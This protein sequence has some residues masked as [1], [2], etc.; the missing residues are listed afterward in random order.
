MAK[1]ST[2]VISPMISK[3]IHEA[4]RVPMASLC[5]ITLALSGRRG[6]ARRGNPAA[7]LTGAPL[8]RRVMRHSELVATDIERAVKDTENIDVS[9][10]LE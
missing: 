10:V 2:L 6:A 8:E 1:V 3:Y 4:F 5:R 7:A 9:I